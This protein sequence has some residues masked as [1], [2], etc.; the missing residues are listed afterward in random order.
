MTENQHLR[1]AFGAW[2][3]G[4]A[5]RADRE[6]NKRFTYGDQWSDRAAC[7]P[8]GL[9][10]GEVL[11]HEGPTPITNNM[12]RRLIKTVVGRFRAV[13]SA[14]GRY[15]DPVS[16]RNSLVELDCRLLEEF[17]ISGAAV[18][19][20]S[21]LRR[22]GVPGPWVDNVDPRRFFVNRFSDPRGCDIELVGMLHDMSYQEAVSRFARGDAGRTALVREVFRRC[23]LSG[24][25]PE[26]GFPGLSSP[27]DGDFF[28]ADD[29]RKMRVAEVWTRDAAPV[30]SGADFSFSWVC[31]WFA[32]DGSLLDI[33]TSPFAHRSH[34]FAVKFYPLIDGEIHSYV[35]GLI[36]NQKYINRLI[37]QVDNILASSA[38]GALIYPV[39]QLPA[40][41]RMQDLADRWARPDAVIPIVG[42]PNV[43]MPAQVAAKGTADGAYRLLDLQMK[44][45]EDNSG[46]GDVLLGK[47]VPASVGADT[48]NARLD[49][50]SLGLL[51]IF[52]SFT[53]FR[54][55]R[56]AKL[57]GTTLK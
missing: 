40:G 23:V 25:A 42:A 47:N 20:L 11:A 18:Q 49:T 29:P 45:F 21:A 15:T 53:T 43:P 41:V 22:E 3:A 1:R 30:R 28:S 34:P 7:G 37:C 48:Y 36:E 5:F 51:D 14:T 27:G 52:D 16:R 46:V 13:N 44:L 55:G 33:H 56:D 54:E 50:A 19:R 17:L 35:E 4:A 39:S 12:I 32:P 57:K 24:E 6:R 8:R 26:G 9:T 31:R 10:E 38:K 2:S